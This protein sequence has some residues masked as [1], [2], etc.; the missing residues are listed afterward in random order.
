MGQTHRYS[1]H[2]I[3]QTFHFLVVLRIVSVLL[4]SR[5]KE[6]DFLTRKKS[7]NLVNV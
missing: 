5:L 4:S 6:L 3:P 1:I 7:V 2:E